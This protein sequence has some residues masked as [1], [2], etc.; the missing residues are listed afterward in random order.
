MP[1]SLCWQELIPEFYH[2]DG[3]FLQNSASLELGI[4]AS[5]RPVSHLLLLLPY[6]PFHSRC[7]VCVTVGW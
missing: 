3:D 1:L 5:G 2:G 7:G 6:Q 4:R